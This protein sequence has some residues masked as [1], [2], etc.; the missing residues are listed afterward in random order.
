[1]E[2]KRVDGRQR[3][4]QAGAER[5]QRCVRR[6]R[7]RVRVGLGWEVEGDRGGVGEGEEQ[8]DRRC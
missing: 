2:D 7:E 5:G 8:R 3:R 4:G 1:M 6:Q